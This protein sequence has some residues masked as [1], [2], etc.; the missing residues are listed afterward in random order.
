MYTLPI[1]IKLKPGNA[2]VRKYR[3]EKL[4]YRLNAAGIAYSGTLSVSN[5]V[6]YKDS[7]ASLMHMFLT[8]ANL[9]YGFTHQKNLLQLE[10]SFQHILKR[11]KNI[12]SKNR[13]NFSL[14]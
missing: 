14:L 6:I 5:A 11:A 8:I 13:C 3:N 9:G 1:N 7:A 4:L 2:I 10:P 12:Y